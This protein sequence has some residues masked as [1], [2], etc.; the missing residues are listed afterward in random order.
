MLEKPIITKYSKNKN[1]RCVIYDK[2]DGHYEVSV[3]E[4]LKGEN[5]GEKW[6]QYNAVKDYTYVT[7]SIDTAVKIA[8]ETLSDLK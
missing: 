2:E 5:M 4:I 7:N 1:H 6:V 3:E 8:E